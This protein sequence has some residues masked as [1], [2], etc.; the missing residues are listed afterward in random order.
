VTHA[1]IERWTIPPKTGS[2]KRVFIDDAFQ[3]FPEVKPYVKSA[4]LCVSYLCV[5]VCVWCIVCVSVCVCTYTLCTY[6]Y[7]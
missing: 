6:M 3:A 7:M 5:C 2:A 1:Q 4:C